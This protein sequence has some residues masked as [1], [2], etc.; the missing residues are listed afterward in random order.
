MI[1]IMGNV[2]FLKIAGLWYFSS[3]SGR[4]GTDFL[5]IKI[6]IL[7]INTKMGIFG[8]ERFL[9]CELYHIRL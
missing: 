6:G 9:I 8:K 3:A 7:M 1:K 5:E 2:L 4:T